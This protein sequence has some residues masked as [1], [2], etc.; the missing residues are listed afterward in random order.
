MIREGERL[1]LSAVVG[2]TAW[3]VVESDP[4]IEP[5]IEGLQGLCV[6]GEHRVYVNRTEVPQCGYEYVVVH[7][8]AHAAIFTTGGQEAL[9]QVSGLSGKKL[10]DLEELIVCTLF[11]S[12]YDTLKRNNWLSVPT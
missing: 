4:S 1:L 6:T 11:H 7:E 5:S 3:S 8:L 12:V 2:G 10:K 9:R